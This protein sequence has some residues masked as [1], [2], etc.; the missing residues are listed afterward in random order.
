M[1][2][3]TIIVERP[4]WP[5]GKVAASAA[6]GFQVRHPI[7]LKVRRTCLLHAKSYV[8]DKR[9]PA[10]VVRKFEGREADQASSS[11]SDRGSKLRGAPLNIPRVV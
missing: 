5:S 1:N 4:R 11:S 8:G 2:L 3:S 10:G 7:P 9:P 6:G